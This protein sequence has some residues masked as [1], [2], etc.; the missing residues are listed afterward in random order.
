MG[1]TRFVICVRSRFCKEL[2]PSVA[3]NCVE[4]ASSGMVKATCSQFVIH[5]SGKLT[6]SIG[7]L[8]RPKQSIRKDRVDNALSWTSGSE[9]NPDHW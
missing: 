4:L 1:F 7:S 5:E 3:V 9:Y 6:I 2:Q 8:L